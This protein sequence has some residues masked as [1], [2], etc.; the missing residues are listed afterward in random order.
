MKKKKNLVIPAVLLVLILLAVSVFYSSRFTGYASYDGQPLSCSSKVVSGINYNASYNTLTDRNS[1]VLCYN[2]Q[3]YECG[4]ISG[5]NSPD[6]VRK[7][8]GEVLG[9]WKCFESTKIWVSSSSC[10]FNLTTSTKNYALNNSFGYD[11]NSSDYRFYCLN[12]QEHECGWE[13]T[14]PSTAIELSSGATAGAYKCFNSSG[15]SRYFNSSASCISYSSGKFWF[16]ESNSIGLRSI[17]GTQK[18]PLNYS[19]LTLNNSYLCYNNAWYLCGTDSTGFSQSTSNNQV[20]GNSFN[21]SNGQWNQLSYPAPQI[22]SYGITNCTCGISCQPF[23]IGMTTSD[24]SLKF[25]LETKYTLINGSSVS[26]FSTIN[27]SFSS[28]FAQGVANVNLDCKSKPGVVTSVTFV[29]RVLTSLPNQAASETLNVVYP[30]TCTNEC[31]LTGEKTC[32]QDSSRTRVCGQNDLDQCLDLADLEVCSG[33]LVCSNGACIPGG[34]DTCTSQGF[35]CTS[36]SLPI[37]STDKS[38]TNNCK[39]PGQK[40]F[41]C[42]SGF[43]WNGTNCVRSNTNC[44]QFNG[45]CSSVAP[46]NGLTPSSS[47][48]CALGNE[49][50]YVCGSGNHYYNGSCISN[51]CSGVAP[52]GS[53]V[54]N[55]SITFAD[56]PAKNWT[57]KMLPLNLSACEWSCDARFTKNIST[58]ST[59][60]EGR[61]CSALDGACYNGSVLPN[62]SINIS[63]YGSCTNPTDSCLICNSS[64]S[65]NKT[66]LGEFISCVPTVPQR[67]CNNA[68][69]YD[70]KCISNAIRLNN[71]TADLYCNATLGS[72]MLQKED[73]KYCDSNYECENNFCNPKQNKCMNLREEINSR[74][75]FFTRLGCL[76]ESITPPLSKGKYNS[77][78]SR[79]AGLNQGV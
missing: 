1:G 16:G 60:Q 23:T 56:G 42:N 37:N 45:T 33:V 77:C 49:Q 17:A 19:G 18:N 52:T 71:G 46:S 24:S 51:S 55:G 54:A 73:G 72:F 66:S 10:L 62:S 78:L 9:S 57:Y 2:A 50:C 53:N 12:G 44:T 43:N 21:C 8:F 6:F 41:S 3:L 4:D 22:Y 39:L 32:S 31:N 63:S 7:S 26:D 20:V 69:L 11:S 30:S 36:G 13:K 38:S 25:S 58:N 15:V 61:L 48:T 59:C 76:V 64:G 47:L 65:L 68:C 75:D 35:N 74:I 67:V 34:V 14:A 79:N 28:N 29:A 27:P 70:G 5:L 40:C